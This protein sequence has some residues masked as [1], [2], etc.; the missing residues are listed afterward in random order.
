MSPTGDSPPEWIRPTED[1]RSARGMLERALAAPRLTGGAGD[2]WVAPSVDQVAALFPGYEILEMIG[3]G[4]MGAVYKARQESLDRLVAIKLL[5]LELSVE[6]DFAERFRREAHAMARLSHPNIV[7]VHD[8]GQT[9]EGHFFIVMEFVEGADLAKLV[10]AGALDP[11][12]AFSI[13]RQVCDA[14]GYAHEHGFV[15]R[16]VKPGNVLLDAT[17]TIA[18]VSDFGVARL[19]DEAEPETMKTIAGGVVGTPAY[20]APEQIRDGASADLRADIYSIGVMFYELLTGELPRGAF[21]PP[22][23]KAAVDRHV[24][25]VVERAMQPEPERRYQS[26]GAMRVDLD[27][28][29]SRIRAALLWTTAALAACGVAMVIFTQGTRERQ[30][31]L[32]READAIAGRSAAA[33]AVLD[34]PA[35]RFENSL[36]MEFVPVAALDLKVCI[37]ETRVRD[38]AE[39]IEATGHDM[40][41]GIYFLR[42]GKVL[43][44]ATSDWRNPPDYKNAPPLPVTGVSWHDAV[45]FCDW[46]TRRE[47]ESGHLAGG[48]RY[49]LLTFQEWELAYGDDRSPPA[50]G[51][52]NLNGEELREAGWNSGM[53]E[54]WRD[55]FASPC[56]VEQFQ[57]NRLGLYGMDGN[58][59]EWVIENRYRTPHNRVV[60]GNDWGLSDPRWNAWRSYAPEARS[61]RIGFR[62]AIAWDRSEGSTAQ[63]DASDIFY[64]SLDMRLTF[65]GTPSVLMSETET[66]IDEFAAFVKATQRDLSGRVW[67][68]D[69]KGGAWKEAGHDWQNP[70][71]FEA[72]PKMPVTCVSWDDAMAFCDW[73]TATERAA[74][75][76]PEGDWHY[77]LPTLEEFERAWNLPKLRKLW[78]I[79]A[80]YANLPGEEMREIG[81]QLNILDGWRDDAT[82]PVLADQPARTAHNLKGLSGNVSEWVIGR[83]HPSAG[84]R[85][86]AGCD[87]LFGELSESGNV[88]FDSDWRG[89]R[90]GFR[91]VLTNVAA[92]VEPAE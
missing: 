51:T 30:R 33:L 85:A 70:P 88:P 31:G 43:H 60:I 19:G 6:E 67:Y 12:Q 58:V 11:P 28:K 42:S 61:T 71:G 1:L 75:L 17:H 92:K 29:P 18:K 65:A 90:V 8:H 35:A 74:G 76:L 3:R 20:I 54:S 73:L 39:F 72:V 13:V 23:R 56:P 48:W 45:A 7:A 15:H 25:E 22:S 89:V 57:P 52:A 2:C 26:A 78:P 55:D 81:W 27:E 38:Y 84:K 37:W 41:G 14:L 16:D 4:G 77:R 83:H 66:R 21:P 82:T 40:G 24:D 62:I 36:G 44:S 87:W 91:V 79:P 10:A 63:L 32:E 64:N 47:R 80:E 46:L 50:P 53:L 49:R 9:D 34:D 68:F 86:C 5:P 59:T 69:G